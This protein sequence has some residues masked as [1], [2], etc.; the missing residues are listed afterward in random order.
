MARMKASVRLLKNSSFTIFSIFHLDNSIISPKFLTLVSY[1]LIA[2]DTEG[3]HFLSFNP[4]S[5]TVFS[6]HSL[7]CLTW[8]IFK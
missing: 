5:Q 7:L 2:P 8:L 3:I 6:T 1:P 4:E